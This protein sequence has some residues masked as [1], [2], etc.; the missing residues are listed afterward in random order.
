MLEIIEV[1]GAPPRKLMIGFI[2]APKTGKTTLGTQI[3]NLE[4]G[5]LVDVEQG[6]DFV[7]YRVKA[8]RPTS[9]DELQLLPTF[10]SD[11]QTIVIDTLDACYDLLEL[12]TQAKL[13]VKEIRDTPY[14]TG[15][16]FARNELTDWLQSLRRA[17]SLVVVLCHIRP[18]LE[19]ESR[20]V[21]LPGKTGRAFVAL[22]DAIGL[23]TV[24]NQQGRL[25]YSVSF[26]PSAGD[27]GSRIKA[28]HGRVFPADWN[29]LRRHVLG[30]QSTQQPVQ[31]QPTQPSKMTK[32]QRKL[33][34]PEIPSIEEIDNLEEL[35]LD[36]DVKEGGA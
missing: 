4:N 36:A 35:P 12:H 34:I 17:F 14:G 27:F 1:G 6:A 13:G 15:F 22:M 16:A 19:P 20:K 3:C 29:I 24:Q 5:L 30:E 31:Q 33:S 7:P 2:G 21:D 25:I 32:Q 8:V 23:L 11:F 10:A 26:D 18:G 9:W 28:L